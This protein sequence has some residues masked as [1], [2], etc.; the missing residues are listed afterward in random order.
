[1][2]LRYLAGYASLLVA[3]SIVYS[4]AYAAFVFGA[5]RAS[6]SIHNK[7][8]D[9]ILGTTLRWLDVVPTSRVIARATTDLRSVD[10]PLSGLLSD[11]IELGVSITCK[12]AA[13]VYMSPI[14]I[15]PGM[16]VTAVG[17][18]CGQLYIAS[19]LSVKRE[20]SNHRAP[21]LGHFGAAITGLSA[22][23]TFLR[24][25]LDSNR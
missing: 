24:A 8:I 15:I 25:L 16:A 20:M 10:G 5:L 13:V 3:G 1:L 17:W 18:W 21:V 14:F 7:L 19:Q 23:L 12:F 22:Y 4:I 11:L 2:S 6:R 9:S